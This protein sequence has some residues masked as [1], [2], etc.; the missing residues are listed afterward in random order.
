MWMKPQL[1]GFKNGRW[2]D[3]RRI[4]S[5]MD[6]GVYDPPLDPPLDPLT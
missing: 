1:N 4:G 3:G 6:E 2:I 5:D